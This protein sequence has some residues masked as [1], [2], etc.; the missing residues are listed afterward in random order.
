MVGIPAIC[1]CIDMRTLELCQAMNIPYIWY[2]ELTRES[3]SVAELLELSL[4]HFNA[5]V[6]DAK[7]KYLKEL[8]N[9]A[10]VCL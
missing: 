7:R 5:D 4:V 10:M 6:F 1:I 9:V 3:Y 2:E 8:F